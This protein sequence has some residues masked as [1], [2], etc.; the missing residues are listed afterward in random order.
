MLA[1]PPPLPTAA[2]HKQGAEAYSFS[3]E[4][5]AVQQKRNLSIEKEQKQ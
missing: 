3:A 4:P 5:K 2:D 1:N